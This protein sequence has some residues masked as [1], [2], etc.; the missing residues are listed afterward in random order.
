MALVDGNCTVAEGWLE[1]LT[2]AAQSD[3]SVAIASALSQRY[4]P[5][6]GDAES[7]H[8]SGAEPIIDGPARRVRGRRFASTRASPYRPVA[9]CISGAPHSS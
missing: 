4:D 5:V 2:R 7:R 3:S 6:V 8:Q 1:G 9:A